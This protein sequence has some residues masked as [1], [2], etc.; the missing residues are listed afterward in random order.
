MLGNWSQFEGGGVNHS[1]RISQVAW[2]MLLTTEI[3]G[4]SSIR[5]NDLVA[6]CHSHPLVKTLLVFRN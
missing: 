6:R 2:S 4:A 1:L 5:L 3:C